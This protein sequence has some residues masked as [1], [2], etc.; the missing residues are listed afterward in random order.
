MINYTP[1]STQVGIMNYSIGQMLRKG[2]LA[3]LT[4]Q[5]LRLE[6][7][8]ILL[9]EILPPELKQQVR[10]ISFANS[11][12][13][14]EISNSSTATLLR[15]YTPTLL[16]QI[17]QHAEFASI[18]SIK[19]QIKPLEAPSQKSFKKIKPRAAYSKNASLLLAQVADKIQYEPLKQALLKLSEHLPK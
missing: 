10:A 7:L 13:L 5:A 3:E 16:G 19:Q 12:L 4:Q 8:Q 17:R 9:Q 18:A 1:I 2:E 6:K 14:L 11:C 15:Y